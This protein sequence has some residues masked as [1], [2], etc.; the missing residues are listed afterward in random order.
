MQ[1]DGRP[2]GRVTARLPIH[3]V[4]V[5]HIEHPVVVRI[6]LEIQRLSHLNI[7][8]PAPTNAVRFACAVNG[9]AS[10][11][12]CTRV[13]DGRLTVGHVEGASTSEATTPKG[14]DLE[15]LYREAGPQR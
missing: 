8:G 4:A 14:S 3:E 15:L 12:L 10:F 13:M 11:E 5:A 2:P 9:T 7:V 1:H 6:D